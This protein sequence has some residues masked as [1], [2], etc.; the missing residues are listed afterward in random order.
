MS[1]PWADRIKLNPKEEVT[2]G[3]G[4]HGIQNT[5]GTLDSHRTDESAGITGTDGMG[6]TGPKVSEFPSQNS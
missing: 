6:K 3:P 4:N 5:T 2:S 1:D